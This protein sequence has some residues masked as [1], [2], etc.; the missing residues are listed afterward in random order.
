MSVQIV[1]PKTGTL[2][3]STPAGLCDPL[4][5]VVYKNV[6]HIPR[7]VATDNYTQN[8][9]FEWN[10]FQKTQIDK[11]CSI[12]LS[13]KRFFAESKWY[14]TL[15]DQNILEV[16]SGAGR[17][18]QIVLDHTEANLYSV[19]Y[20][21]AVEANYK[22]NGPNQRLNLFQASVY[23]LP[24]SEKQFDKVF[25]FGVL[26]HTPDFE[27]SITCLCNMVKPNGELVVDFYPIK[28]WYSK[29]NAKYL[30]RPFTK[31]MSHLKLLQLITK[32]IAWMMNLYRFNKKIGLGMLNRFIPICDIDAT[33]P[34][35]VKQSQEWAILDTFDMFSPQ[36][37]QPQ[38]LETVKKWFLKNGMTQVS[39]EMI[40][41][42]KGLFAAVVRGKASQK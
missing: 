31:K 25:C 13:Y 6:N 19:D 41:Y 7:L 40:E 33:F 34:D 15:T 28:G 1:C 2:L 23:E 29:I 18:S 5:N 21:N 4:G 42:E 30:L 17:F 16:G 26:Q 22:N 36:Y 10:T 8:F 20:S 32:N 11:H 38:R 37:D 24:F 27:K 3:T 9:G 35:N 14:E 12:D 39:A